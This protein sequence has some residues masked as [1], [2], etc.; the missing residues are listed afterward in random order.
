MAALAKVG[1]N[2]TANSNG[3]T[4]RSGGHPD[5]HTGKGKNKT[6]R[7][8]PVGAPNKNRSAISS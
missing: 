8:W 1:A 5:F 6:G 2:I 4:W 3:A 7:D